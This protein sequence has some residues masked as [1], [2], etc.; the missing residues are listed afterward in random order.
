MTATLDQLG[1]LYLKVKELYNTLL[2][3]NVERLDQ[4]AYI[5]EP[6]RYDYLDNNTRIAIARVASKITKQRGWKW[7]ID[8]GSKWQYIVPMIDSSMYKFSES[9][10]RMLKAVSLDG[11]ER[12]SLYPEDY[13]VPSRSDAHYVIIDNNYSGVRITRAAFIR[14]D[15][16][17]ISMVYKVAINHSSEKE[18]L[19]DT[20]HYGC[21]FRVIDNSPGIAYKICLCL[22]LA[23]DVFSDAASPISVKPISMITRANVIETTKTIMAID[24]LLPWCTI[25]YKRTLIPLPNYPPAHYICSVEGSSVLQVLQ[26]ILPLDDIIDKISGKQPKRYSGIVEDTKTNKVQVTGNAIMVGFDNNKIQVPVFV[27]RVKVIAPVTSK[28]KHIN[29]Y[30]TKDRIPVR[31]YSIWC[32]NP[33]MAKVSDSE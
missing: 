11:L 30:C 23:R 12:G 25:V 24:E 9:S 5:I 16:D 21:R 6:I 7:I 2:S 8:N 4:H 22:S 29:C 13:I 31:E 18:V 19:L 1:G 15:D 10:C 26:Y 14:N 17:T 20:P 27:G 3:S 33:V 28:T 32:K